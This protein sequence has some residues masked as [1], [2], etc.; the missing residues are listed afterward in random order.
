MHSSRVRI[1]CLRYRN[2]SLALAYNDSVKHV[3]PGTIAAALA[4]S[5]LLQAQSANPMSTELKAAYNSV[6]NNLL[7]SAEKMP[8]ENYGFKPTPDIRSFAEVMNHAAM[9][10][11]H[12]CSA[13]LGDQSAS[14]SNAETKADVRKAF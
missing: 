14:M 6:K 8:D 5:L 1:I 2:A 12:T 10:Q 13:V 9:A 3:L 7:K 4:F 11:L